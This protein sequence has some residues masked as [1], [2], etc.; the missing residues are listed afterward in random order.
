V[1]RVTFSTKKGF[2][3]LVRF[4]K[5]L[6]PEYYYDDYKNASWVKELNDQR[7]DEF[8]GEQKS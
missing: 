8:C 6:F 2:V 5:Q 1:E 7:R 4:L 3:G